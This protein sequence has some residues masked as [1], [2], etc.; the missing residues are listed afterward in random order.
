[1]AH[2]LDQNEGLTMPELRSE[3][4]FTV[5]AEIGA[6]QRI[7]D[8]PLGR[9]VIWPVTGGNFGGPAMSGTVLPGGGDWLLG[10][11]DGSRQLDVRVTLK[12]QD[13][14]LIYFTHR[15]I[16]RVEPEYLER[17]SAGEPVEPS[18]VHY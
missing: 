3:Y 14:T 10:R 13:E 9:R 16:I 15:G 12:T 11:N 17:F 6:P 18:H 2:T 5:Y 8:T 1:M 7:R 4:L